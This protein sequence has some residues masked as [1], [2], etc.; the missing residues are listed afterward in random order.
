VETLQTMTL[1]PNVLMQMGIATV[2][3]HQLVMSMESILLVI[4]IRLG[5]QSTAAVAAVVKGWI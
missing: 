1:P 2:I 5:T 4:V 3:I